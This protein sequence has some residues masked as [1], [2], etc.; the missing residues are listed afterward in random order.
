[1]P[2]RTYGTAFG[3]AVTRRTRRRPVRRRGVSRRSRRVYRGRRRTYRSRGRWVRRGWY[4]GAVADQ[5]PVG[6]R[7]IARWSSSPGSDWHHYTWKDNFETTSTTGA[8]YFGCE[9]V[10]PTFRSFEIF[11]AWG[12]QGGPL[13]TLTDHTAFASKEPDL[14][15]FAQDYPLG[16]K[17]ILRD[18]YTTVEITPQ[19]LAN[20]EF[21]I[22]FHFV[23]FRP[24]YKSTTSA[25]TDVAKAFWADLSMLDVSN[26]ERYEIRKH[27]KWIPKN[28]EEAAQRYVYKLKI[29]VN[30]MC[31]TITGVDAANAGDWIYSGESGWYLMVFHNDETSVDGQAFDVRI[32]Q[33]ITWLGQS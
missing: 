5:H 17:I 33:R 15:A 9:L 21:P 22:E 27:D 1:M 6:S 31:H 8:N 12:L 25:H 2:K 26:R 16:E 29:P 28:Q 20:V 19:N 14:N 30:R 11:R 24:K 32:K 4:R 3:S 10:S 13:G 7:Q 18:T 23:V